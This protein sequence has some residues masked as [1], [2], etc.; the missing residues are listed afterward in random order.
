MKRFYPIVFNSGCKSIEEQ[1]QRILLMGK[2]KLKAMFK[3]AVAQRGART[4]DP[5]IKSL[6]LYR[7]SLKGNS[8]RRDDIMSMFRN[9]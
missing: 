9:R 3:I 4:H 1:F 5:E 2:F 8:N 6:M 7:L